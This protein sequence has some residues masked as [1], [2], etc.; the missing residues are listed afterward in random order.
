MICGKY[1]GSLSLWSLS[2]SCVFRAPLPLSKSALRFA[3]RS[4]QCPTTSPDESWHNAAP[5][6]GHPGGLPV[7]GLSHG[8][9]HSVKKGDRKHRPSSQPIWAEGSPWVIQTKLTNST[10]TLNSSG[11][12]NANA[13]I[14]ITQL[15][16]SITEKQ[17]NTEFLEHQRKPG[18]L[19]NNVY[20]HWYRQQPDQPLH[21]IL[22]IS[23]NEN[24][25][26]EQGVS[27]VRFETRKKTE[28][29]AAKLRIHRV[30]EA[31]A[32]LDYYPCSDTL[33]WSVEIIKVFGLGTKLRL[34]D[35]NLDADTSPK[36]TIFLPSVA[37]IKFHK[38]GTYLCLLENFFPEVIKID[39]QEKDG[40]RILTSRQ[41][42][43]M[44]TNDTY[45]KFSWLTVT[46]KSIAKEHK[47]IVTHTSNKGGVNEEILF[48]SMK[49]ELAAIDSEKIEDDILQLQ[50]GTT[51]AYYTYL[52]L[53]F[54]TLV[55][56]A[57]IA[58]Y[59]FG[60]PALCGNEKSS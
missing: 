4:A 55:Y 6:T 37:E 51:S 16:P 13:D 46:K 24:V 47:C 33:Q 38:V 43:T 9:F 42:D 31:D 27:E 40:K 59:L 18:I 11:R 32:G 8:T 7:S 60:G 28:G 21:R 22:Y 44:K 19:R 14:L 57:I 41:G 48:R 49:K 56:S 45:V 53:F 3:L 23:A 35:R 29:V 25:V 54:K 1:C 30:N 26:H 39:W 36:P 17:R 20:I 15:I 12:K 2:L 5:A 50:L 58:F 52:L 10:M 34:T